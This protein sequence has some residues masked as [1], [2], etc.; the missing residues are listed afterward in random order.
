M[1]QLRAHHYFSTDHSDEQLSDTNYRENEKDH[2]PVADH[3]SDMDVVLQHKCHHTEDSER[4][5]ILCPPVLQHDASLNDSHVVDNEDNCARVEGVKH[6]GK[7]TLV[8]LFHA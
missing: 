8:E 4:E 5:Q 6:E 7:V 1:S 3:E 2:T